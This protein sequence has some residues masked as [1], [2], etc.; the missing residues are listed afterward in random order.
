MRPA[1][2]VM[3]VMVMESAAMANGGPFLVRSANG[4]TA[5][6]GVPAPILPDL[7]PG[8]ESRLRVEREDLAVDFNP[9][10][11]SL[12]DVT[13]RYTIANPGKDDI[14]LDIGFPILRGIY[15]PYHGGGMGGPGYRGPPAV[16][17]KLGEK[18][19]A[20]DIISNTNLLARIREHAYEIVET[21]ITRMGM[22]D[23]YERMKSLTDKQAD[24]LQ[25]A[26]QAKV[27]K[28][29]WSERDARLLAGFVRAVAYVVPEPTPTPPEQVREQMR[30]T[31]DEAG[32]NWGHWVEEPRTG[33]IPF[34]EGTVSIWGT[35]HPKYLGTLAS[36]GE[37][38]AT[39]LLSHLASLFDPAAGRSYENIFAAWGGDV[40]ERA[41]DMTSGA[42]RPRQ[43]VAPDTLYARVDY[44]QE[45]LVTDPGRRAACKQILADL[46]VT[47]TF[48]PMSLIHT[49]VRFPG[50][51][52]LV[53]EFNYVQHPFVDSGPPPSY[54]L[55][56]VVH[57]ASFW[58]EFGPIH[59][60]VRV[61]KGVPFRA[62]APLPKTKSKP[63]ENVDRYEGELGTK[64]GEL[65]LGVPKDEWWKAV[66]AASERESHPRSR[67]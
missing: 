58:S 38:K 24:V 50:Q 4:D 13:A 26:L 57:P 23:I 7:L 44:F 52:R 10:A 17:V 49:R 29:G 41:V 45:G 5:A 64:T 1:T 47:F 36:L 12:V 42:E 25:A 61:P 34:V 35:S 14:S 55:A 31:P 53:L 54:Q 56:Y 59:V 20:F 28:A 63:A 65:F 21:G 9:N 48:A 60:T 16:H 40:R 37:V 30:R 3:L 11:A 2:I 8:R 67:R 33:E 39:Q 22:K 62:S 6:K 46:P 32:R 19:Q 18:H 15:Q 66:N 27:R 51:A 43:V